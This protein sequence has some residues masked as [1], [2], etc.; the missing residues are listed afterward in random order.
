M[1]PAIPQPLGVA[2]WKRG[3]LLG[4]GLQG[5][6]TGLEVL[7]RAAGLEAGL[8][9]EAGLGLVGGAAGQELEQLAEG[10]GQRTC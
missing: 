4:P 6:E 9:G 8:L 10:L 2:V 3:G 7:G 1:Q 5:G